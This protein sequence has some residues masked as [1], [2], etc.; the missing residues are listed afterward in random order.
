MRLSIASAGLAAALVLAPVAVGDARAFGQDFSIT[1]P[2]EPANA[3]HRD[4]VRQLQALWD[5]QA[6]YPRHASNGNESGTVRVHLVILPDGRIWTIDVVGGSG[7]RTLDTAG[8]TV[9]RGEHLRPFGTASEPQ[10]DIDL[11]LHY[12]LAYRRGEPAAGG[13]PPVVS[14]GPFTITNEPVKSPVLTTM[15]QRTCTGTVTMGGIAN[16]PVYGTHS[17]AQAIF[18]RKPDGTPW[19]K[20]YERGT[21]S[22]SPVTQIGR[23]VTWTG[24]TQINQAAS[25]WFQYTVWPD[26]DNHLTGMIGSRIFND[27]GAA[28]NSNL[29][30]NSVE[31]TCAPETL[32]TV[33]WNDMLTTPAATS[34]VDLSSSDPP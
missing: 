26:D 5:K 25:F 22:L 24:R 10:A 28:I 16:N 9:F 27:F 7:S 18:F 8:E 23:M 31:L 32:P 19:V 3:G 13:S 21:P 29:T 11:S 1:N 30:G 4:L 14:K 2:E 17:W 6:Y 12:V 33:T 15:L 34:P 20:F